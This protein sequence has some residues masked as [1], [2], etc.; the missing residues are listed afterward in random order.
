MQNI[1]LPFTI[2]TI[3]E[4]TPRKVFEQGKRYYESGFV[5]QVERRGN[6]FSGKIIGDELHD[7]ILLDIAY[8]ELK[9]YASAEGRTTKTEVISAYEVALALAILADDYRTIKAPDSEPTADPFE[10]V[11]RKIPLVQKEEF[12]KQAI[13][14][15]PELRSQF[16]EFIRSLQFADKVVPLQE[17]N[18]RL[19]A[20]AEDVATGLQNL[21]LSQEKKQKGKVVTDEFEVS[22]THKIMTPRAQVK[23]SVED[24]LSSYFARSIH[25]AKEGKLL[26]ASRV[27]FGIY[28]GTRISEV[29]PNFTQHI[30][31]FQWKEN[32]RGYFKQQI[33]YLSEDIMNKVIKSEWQAKASLDLFMLHF[34]EFISGNIRPVPPALDVWF[35]ALAVVPNFAEYML[36]K[37]DEQGMLREDTVNF[38]LQIAYIGKDTRL[39]ERTAKRFAREDLELTKQLLEHYRENKQSDEF[40]RL[41]QR[42]F[43]VWPT[44]LLSY[45]KEHT[46]PKT[47]RALYAEIAL[48]Q[49]K[50]K[51]DIK[52]YKE[53]QA[54][55]SRD[56]R[57]EFVDSF[58]TK[59]DKD[60]I[61]LT[62]YIQLLV[63]EGRIQVA[64]QAIKKAD[65]LRFDTVFR[66]LIEPFLPTYAKE[67]LHIVEKRIEDRLEDKDTPDDIYAEIPQWLLPFKKI[68]N[69]QLELNRVVQ[70]CYSHE[71]G[72]V[73]LKKEL[74]Q[75]GFINR[76]ASTVAI[77]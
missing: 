63:A 12:Y 43:K 27:L 8:G 41:G 67:A 60:P 23:Q 40:Q 47:Q 49:L 37:Y 51:F 55:L 65:K 57:I 11:L 54:Y 34:N 13:K 62:M 71:P 21:D 38:F 4:L 77:K 74:A 25:F 56:E 16:V 52:Y 59:A 48:H 76:K 73:K 66:D 69:I 1:T 68:A 39:W 5:Q 64:T 9:F 70:N 7:R 22:P 17:E 53:M 44:D 19:N 2:E 58:A 20:I 31:D 35:H 30:S 24:F 42:A 33:N 29:P 36:K 72:I 75:F 32:L 26:D 28:E 14:Q 6:R 10:V 18:R 3:K 45:L 46:D 50:L 15:H 61:A